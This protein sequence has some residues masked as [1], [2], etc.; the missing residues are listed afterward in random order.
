MIQLKICMLLVLL[1]S[2]G[3]RA[4]AQQSAFR[5]II[6]SD[7]LEAG[8][9]LQIDAEYAVGDRQ[10]P[11]ATLAVTLLKDGEPGKFWQMRWPLVNGKAT[12]AVVLPDS[13]P[14]GLYNMAFAVQPRFL[15]FYCDYIY[16]QK[17]T[18]LQAVFSHLGGI[19]RLPFKATPNRRFV[20]ED[21][22]ITGDVTLSFQQPNDGDG[23]PVMM[24]V[25]AWLDSS[26]TPAAYGVKQLAVN[27]RNDSSYKPQRL[28]KETFFKGDFSCFQ[29]N[30]GAKLK[31]EKVA[32]LPLAKQFDSLYIP[33]ALKEGAS[34]VYDCLEDS[35]ATAASNVY[36]LLQQR[37]KG[38]DINY[39]GSV[40][41]VRIYNQS[42]SDLQLLQNELMLVWKD[43]LYRL[44]FDGVY[45]DASIMILPPG[46]F[47]SIR[48]FDPPFY[49]EP[50][51][52]K[53]FGTIAVFS[54]RYPFPQPF[55]YRSH[56]QIRGYTPV[57]F[58]LPL[59]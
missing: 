40:E 30:Y 55:P 1:A 14:A 32:S 26:F 3:N 44:Y 24:R 4:L 5:V 52:K 48:I 15:K 42:S 45:G 16:P 9:T 39:W 22:L 50:S 23:T 47:G 7:Y 25:D 41:N 54:K 33:A 58:D 20:M 53:Q 35:E 29:G 27:T 38:F 21:I 12:A 59:Q 11:P 17:P 31:A 10:L 57:V 56:F 8:D 13:M 43:Q 18:H 28:Y 36:E 37:L 19:Q 2:A 51:T 6:N 49:T 34:H 46:A